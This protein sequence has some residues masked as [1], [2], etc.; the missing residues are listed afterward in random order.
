[1]SK[2]KSSSVPQ[3][4]GLFADGQSV[5]LRGV[6]I[7]VRATGVASRVTVA[8]RYQNAGGKT[9]HFGKPYEA[10]Y[11][12]CLE[13]L[14]GTGRTKILAVGD[15]FETD[16]PGAVSMGIDTLFV[17]GGIHGEELG[18]SPTAGRLEHFYARHGLS[19]TASIGVFKWK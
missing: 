4:G 9:Y 1:M 8:Q 19:P 3:A 17:I 18:N 16:I 12:E 15:S 6:A 5:P 7:D 11:Q 10:I 13:R 2:I 14:E